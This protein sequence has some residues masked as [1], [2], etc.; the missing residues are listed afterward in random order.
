MDRPDT[1][2][3]SLLIIFGE[4]ERSFRFFKHKNHGRCPP[5]PTL[6]PPV[7][8]W[9][10]SGQCACSPHHE[11]LRVRS[12]C[13]N[14]SWGGANYLN[15]YPTYPSSSRESASLVER[16]RPRTSTLDTLTACV[17]CHGL[18]KVDNR[19]S[20]ICNTCPKFIWMGH[21]F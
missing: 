18:V 21:S 15:T 19:P 9:P 16:P 5:R 20:D 10:R 2:T 8:L 1:S 3:T 7:A 11:R 4:T 14:S 12:I 6:P 13:Y 17:S